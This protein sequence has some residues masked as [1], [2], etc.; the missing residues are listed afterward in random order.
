MA[1]SRAH[2]PGSSKCASS[3]RGAARGALAETGSQRRSPGKREPRKER[4]RPH[5]T[6]DHR[7][8]SRQLQLLAQLVQ[9]DPRA[10]LP[11]YPHIA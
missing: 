11:D 10:R 4:V 7:E 6:T 2:K 8:H 1:A 9:S 5:A 3:T